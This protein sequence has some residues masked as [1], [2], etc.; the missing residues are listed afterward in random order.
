M[1]G[2]ATFSGTDYQGKTIAYVFIHVLTETKLRWLSILNDTPSAV[3]GEVKGPGDDARVEFG[4]G[5]PVIELQAKHGLKGIKNVVEL[6]RSIERGSKNGNTVDVILVVD[7]TSSDSIRF[8]LRRDVERLRSGR[9]DGLRESTR[10]VLEAYGDG[11]EGVLRRLHV[12]T[13][14]VDTTSD[15]DAKLALELLADSL[16]DPSQAD[17]AFAIFH[18][19][20]SETCAR[21]LRHNRDDLINVLAR[22]GIRLLPRKKTRRWHDDLRISKKLIAD[23]DPAAALALINQIEPEL[24]GG[25]ADADVLYRINQHKAAAYLQL[26]KIDTA[27][28]FAKKALDHNPT[29]LH[30][31]ITLANAQALAGQTGPAH[32]A[33]SKAL[34]HHPDSATAWVISRQ[35]AALA[36]EP[37][38]T[39]PAAVAETVDYRRGTAQIDV[40]L[41]EAKR[42]RDTLAELIREG[43][44]SATTLILRVE[45]L[46][47]DIDD[48]DVSER[49]AR[50]DEIERL[51]TE[52]IEGTGGRSLAVVRRALIGRALAQ[53]LFGRPHEAQIDVDRA[54]EISPDDP[55]VIAQSVQTAIQRDDVDGALILLYRPI[56]DEDAY[57]LAM[58]AGLLAGKDSKAARRDL[59]AAIKSLADASSPEQ[60]RSAAAETAIVLGDIPLA[61]SLLEGSSEG[62]RRSPHFLLL[63]GRIAALE[64]DLTVATALYREAAEQLP[65]HRTELLS[66]LASRL[67]VAKDT[68]GAIEIYRDLS[69]LPT[70]ARRAYLRALID[71]DELGEA[72][73][74]LD[75]LAN[76]GGPLPD[77]AIEIAAQIAVRRNDPVA[78]ANHLEELVD[79]GH[80]TPSATLIL[81]DTLL[82]LGRPEQ[83]DSHIRRLTESDELDPLERMHLATALI[84]RGRSTDAMDIAVQVF[85]EAPH[86]PDVNRAFASVVLK[87]KLPPVEVDTVSPDSHVV[88]RDSSGETVE[89][90]IFSDRSAHPLPHE[91]DVETANS[92]G[93]I[94]C[95]VGS[96]IVQNPNSWHKRDLRVESIQSATKFLFNDVLANYETRFPNAPFFVT[97]FKVDPEHPSIGDLQPM[98]A[99]TQDRE[100]RI[101]EVLTVYKRD[102]LPLDFIA[103]VLGGSVPALMDHISRAEGGYPL[104]VEWSD[105]E[106]QRRSEAAARQDRTIVL[107]RSTLVTL[108]ALPLSDVVAAN[109]RLIAPRSLRDSLVEE[110]AEAE[111][112]IKDGWQ[113]VVAGPVGLSF[114]SLPPEHEVLVRRRD[115]AKA[116]LEWC[117]ANV[118]FKPRPLEAFGASNDQTEEGRQ[119][120][121]EAASDSLELAKHTPACLYADDLGLRRLA[122]TLAI[123]SFSTVSLLQV[124][125]ESGTITASDRNRLLVVLIG[126]HYTSIPASVEL[127]TASLTEEAATRRA[128]F[129]LLVSPNITPMR[130]GQIAVGVAKVQ[131]LSEIRHATTAEIVNEALAAMV[132]KFPPR[133]CAQAIFRVAT[134]ELILLPTEFAIVRKTCLDFL[135]ARGQG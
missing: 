116:R 88:L 103:N 96:S 55:A 12:I 2:S 90:L 97:G 108:E 98:I 42:A 92:I 58:R 26:R 50:A 14:D 23:D 95:K 40:F 20:A 31:L 67:L 77:W 73:Q 61:K 112:H 10:K 63:R 3:E 93:L 135:K 100:R 81:I 129:G 104:H 120:L 124:L 89:Y 84:R 106:G 48:V 115:S 15:R 5:V 51:C 69:P 25:A 85:R 4:A 56:V 128:A 66:E 34:E 47:A 72:Q 127:L 94:G 60:A 134:E 130:A 32:A 117:D 13:L 29:G 111:Q 38:P 36:G 49:M 109:R 76:G 27:I 87:S 123:E 105:D 101:T 114:Q 30:A 102:P 44:R 18:K 45:S 133:I 16:E 71:I 54:R 35:V 99:S 86:N 9:S 19:L 125:S 80:A 7:S 118:D 41:G 83:T 24:A 70:K 121:G 68:R 107:T 122:N 52:L 119:Q 1:S 82:E 6:L 57:L 62:F 126:R 11:C 59:D 8:D 113:V 17:A 91:I 33:A 39:P 131:A 79:H 28:T 74:S 110:L 21:R 78:A 46:I 53:R 132:H 65:S 75:E 22:A 64:N 37:L 43:D